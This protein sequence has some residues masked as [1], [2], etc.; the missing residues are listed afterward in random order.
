M[1]RL[2]GNQG[3]GAHIKASPEAVHVDLALAAHG[4]PAPAAAQ[5]TPAAAD[6]IL[7]GR[8]LRIVRTCI[9]PAFVNYMAVAVP[10]V[11]Q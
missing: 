2:T 9:R 8:Q 3:K 10:A 1:D 11:R 7:Q 6:L 5:R 4:F